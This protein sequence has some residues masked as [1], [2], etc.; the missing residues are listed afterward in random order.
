MI[1]FKAA[2]ASHCATG[3]FFNLRRFSKTRYE[4]P[5]S[6]GGQ[7]PYW[8]E[9]SLLAFIRTADIARL[10]KKGLHNLLENGFSNNYWSHEILN[11]FKTNPESAWLG[12]GWRQFLSWFGKCERFLSNQNALESVENLLVTAENN[13]Q[14]LT[15]NKVLL[16]EPTNDGNWI[17]NWRQALIEYNDRLSGPPF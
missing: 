3:K 17:R 5:S 12:L 7:L 14:T 6:G 15:K 13:W 2:G 1:L 16:D 8:F 4:E 10:Q 11:Q 9:Q